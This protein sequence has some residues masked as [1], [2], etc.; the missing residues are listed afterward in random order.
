MTAKKFW[1]IIGVIIV[2]SGIFYLVVT[3][4]KTKSTP[5]TTPVATST[6]EQ[7]QTPEPNMPGT[8]TNVKD[9]FRTN[10]A[11]D[12]KVPEVNEKLSAEQAKVIAVP[13]VVTP[14]APGVT[15]RYRS[16]NIQANAGVFTPSS[17]IGN[18]NDTM[19]INFSAVDKDYDIVFPSYNMKG[20]I[21]KGET[22]PMQFQASQEGNFVFYCD[23][24]GGL[25][26][27]ATGSIII[28][29]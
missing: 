4:M 28:K 1:L 17:I 19:H 8:G 16:F 27:A 20:V 9:Q 5:V 13:T 10:V 18:V 7:A 14:A 23:S 11:A 22:K 12:I 3:K 15:Q 21:K 2:I 6:P 24:C 25:K 26:S 29:K